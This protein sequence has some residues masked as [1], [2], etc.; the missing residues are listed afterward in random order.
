MSE[1]QNKPPTISDQGI[2]PEQEKRIREKLGRE[3][4][5]KSGA[6]WFYWIAGLSVINSIVYV[7]GG[8]LSFVIGLGATQLVDV[9]VRQMIGANSAPISLA[10]DIFIAGI[11][12]FFGV[13]SNKGRQWAFI[14][15]MV[16]YTIDGLLFV[17]VKDF[18]GIG[19]HL[20]ALFFIFNGYRALNKQ[21][22]EESG[23]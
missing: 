1:L 19:F 18:F 3:N 16:L 20:F 7:T 2:D 11:F 6:N 5:F 9:I 10:I 21:A 23:K 15:G 12:V 8:S 4:N 13:F 22:A 14:A 17:Y